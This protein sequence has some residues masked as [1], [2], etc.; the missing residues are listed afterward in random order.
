MASN[1]HNHFCLIDKFI[2]KRQKR[3][4][5]CLEPGKQLIHTDLC[6]HIE[7]APPL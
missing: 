7:R 2:Q 3:F 1:K 5:Y 6:P 4:P